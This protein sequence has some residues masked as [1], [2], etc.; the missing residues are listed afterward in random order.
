MK[1]KQ[2]TTLG[3]LCAFAFALSAPAATVVNNG[4]GTG[5]VSATGAIVGYGVVSTNTTNP[6]VIVWYGQNDGN[7]NAAWWTSS[8]NLGAK[9]VGTNTVTLTNLTSGRFY[10]YRAGGYE[11]T[12]AT[13]WASS[14][15]SFWTVAGVPTN[16]PAT[17]YRPVMVDTNGSLAAPTNFFGQNG[18]GLVGGEMG[19]VPRWFQPPTN[20]FSIPYFTQDGFDG[21]LQPDVYFPWTWIASTNGTGTNTTLDGTTVMKLAQATNFSFSVPRWVDAL[22]AGAMLSKGA[23]APGRAEV[24]PGAGVYCVAFADNEDAD[25]SIQMQHGAAATNTAFPVWYYGPHAHVSKPTHV[26]GETNASFVLMHQ[27][28][29]PNGTYGAT[30]YQT[31]TV[32]ITSTNGHFL[33]A[34]DNVTNSAM[35]ARDSIVV[36][37]NL[38]RIPAAASN[39]TAEVNVDSIDFHFP[40]SEYGSSQQNGD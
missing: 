14:T 34:F 8:T 30:V 31:N 22:Y 24:W 23:S 19:Q 1:M 25:F 21:A 37:G 26:A 6:V 29:F 5:L 12:N 16:L 17:V 38:K 11:G 33:L 9:A 10:Y 2:I 27:I 13:N 40:V 36:R 18:V 35:Q 32:A 4:T 20:E 28:G 15:L 39:I 3:V 7:S